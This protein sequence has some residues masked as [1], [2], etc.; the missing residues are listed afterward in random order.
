MIPVTTNRFSDVTIELTE[1]IRLIRSKK[2]HSRLR[3]VLKTIVRDCKTLQS[4]LL[5]N[6]INAQFVLLHRLEALAE[7]L[8][9][10][11]GKDDV[12]VFRA[13]RAQAASYRGIGLYAEAEHL[14][15]MHRLAEPAR[16]CTKR[17]QLD[18]QNQ[19]FRA[20]CE[21]EDSLRAREDE[22]RR[23]RVRRELEL[24]EQELSES[25]HTGDS[26][27][28]CFEGTGGYAGGGSWHGDFN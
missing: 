17:A 10:T 22:A 12:T 4:S 1:L 20:E 15:H 6:R 23:E 27:P 5:E 25:W 2:E 13:R 16:S 3:E 21:R 18:G 28:S 19:N 8:T 11:F 14:D 24:R 7:F 26:G 9:D